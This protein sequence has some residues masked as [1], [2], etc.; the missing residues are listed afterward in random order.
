[1][2]ITSIDKITV[3]KT[4][5]EFVIEEQTIKD[6][7]LR[8]LK[9][10]WYGKKTLKS[11]KLGSGSFNQIF[12]YSKD[13]VLRLSKRRKQKIS[14]NKLSFNMGQKHPEILV[15]VFAY[16][17]VEVTI[18]QR[19]FKSN[20]ELEWA[21]VERG[22]GSL[23]YEFES[24]QLSLEQIGTLKSHI[25]RF[26][27]TCPGGHGDLKPENILVMK[28]G[29]F[30][31]IDLPKFQLDL[32][33]SLN[34][35]NHIWYNAYTPGFRDE[36][37]KGHFSKYLNLKQNFTTDKDIVNNYFKY[38]DY[39]ALIKIVLDINRDLDLLVNHE[40][41]D[42]TE[43]CVGFIDKLYKRIFAKNQTLADEIATEIFK[44]YCGGEYP[45]CSYNAFLNYFINEN[46]VSSQ[47]GARIKN[48]R[49]KKKY[50]L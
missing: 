50:R 41:R 47:G 9:R 21:I 32:Y 27:T 36:I 33:K 39:F 22:K 29:S 26:L 16:G 19:G 3:T 42:I 46:Q 34:I 31:I 40:L 43:F 20:V 28:D 5:S 13:K 12:E 30:R 2:K 1:M 4:L 48:K 25:D 15:K 45:R 14:E 17:T 23:L 35:S 6:I 24:E 38:Q 11:R 7:I 44:K 8:K 10:N 49:T 18:E 37:I